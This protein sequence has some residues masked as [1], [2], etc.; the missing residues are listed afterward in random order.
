M[1][2]Q[3]SKFKRMV[4]LCADCEHRSN[5]PQRLSSK[6][7]AKELRK[8]AFESPVPCRVARTPCLGLCPGNALAAVALGDALPAMAAE[9]KKEAHV[10]AFA[11]YAFGRS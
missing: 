10:K 4:A 6:Q 7:V 3:A 11:R 5:G 1:K 8:L 2:L 9:L